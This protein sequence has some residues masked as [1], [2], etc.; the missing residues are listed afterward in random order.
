MNIKNKIAAVFT[1]ISIFA[2]VVNAAP[3]NVE[4]DKNHVILAGYDAVA[5]FTENKP[6]EGSNQYTATHN[7]AIYHFSSKQN[8]DTFNAN[9]TK[10]EPQYGGFCAYG[11]SLGKKFEVNGK[12]FEVVDG[13]L[14]VNKNES[15]YEA[16]VEDKAE[17]ID[18]ANKQWEVIEH[19][20][21]D[22]L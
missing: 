22:K 1:L 2:G 18:E 13:K 16:W 15:V 3:A 8:R 6:V 5:Y 9:P 10:Y 14:Y 7:N 20:E 17:N 19:I 12:A 11:A 4:V 21:A